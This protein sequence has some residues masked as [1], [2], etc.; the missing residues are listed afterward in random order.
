MAS[1]RSSAA[2]SYASQIYVALLGIVVMP[3]Y[4]RH[5]GAE[6]YGLVGVFMLLQ[7]WF[8]VLDLGLAPTLSRE[9]ARYRGGVT[10]VA[11]L[12]SLLFGMEWVSVGVVLASALLVVASAGWIAG[13]WLGV[14]Q[15][16]LNVVT[17]SIVLMGLAVP[18]R[19]MCGL[20]RGAVQGLEHLGWLAASNA[21]FGSLRF[22][23]ALVLVQA[24]T[25]GLVDFF[26]YQ[27]A[28]SVLELVCMAVATHR[29][30]PPR[31]GNAVR[32]FDALR[33]VYRFSV[34][35]SLAGIVWV[36]V[37]QIDKFLLSKALSLVAFGYVSLA[38]AVASGVVLL[39][40]P[41]AS[42]ILPRLTSL[43]AADQ[44]T[45]LEALYLQATE[46][47]GLI[48]LPAAAVL[49]LFPSQVMLAWTGDADAARNSAALVTLYSLGNLLLVFS[50]FPYYLQ[51][52][53]GRV[54]A[55]T[56]VNIGLAVLMVPAV[57]LGIRHS[58]ATGAAAAWLGAVAAYFLLWVPLAHH[59]YAPGLYRAWL[60]R[61]CKL[62]AISFGTAALLGCVM[63]WSSYRAWLVLTLV[64]AWAGATFTIA[65][66]SPAIQRF[67]KTLPDRRRLLQQQAK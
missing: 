15:L 49:A 6:A 59:W 35:I 48:V 40:G 19:W 38:A 52:A 12:R 46:W 33:R 26:A 51:Y 22:L 60:W 18:L 41:L 62:T 7:A 43:A 2:A 16:P 24:V 9:A 20:Y 1:L 28:V 8:Q 4:L 34:A 23:G 57:V 64:A 66:A 29:F 58:G 5:M 54:R 31:Q 42:V 55:H 13:N 67:V 45:E 50:A 56:L 10:T 32:M 11:E 53:Y 25:N 27:L 17:A 44:T 37:T 21:V 3:L 14:E 47:T 39:G 36:L 65:L 30:I 61:I 63:P